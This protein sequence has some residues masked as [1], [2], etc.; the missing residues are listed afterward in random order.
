MLGD[1]TVSRRTDRR[2]LE[3]AAQ[4]CV[5]VWSA[6]RTA[7]GF[8]LELVRAWWWKL[9]APQIDV[10]DDVQT[11]PV[12]FPRAPAMTDAMFAAD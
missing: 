3:H 6:R 11:E 1:D 8:A 5:H 4:L 12:A 9:R 2:D 10:T 7:R